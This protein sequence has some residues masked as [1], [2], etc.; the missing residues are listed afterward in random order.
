[1]GGNVT[2]SFR[3]SPPRRRPLLDY[4]ARPG[5]SWKR[6]PNCAW[7]DEASHDD[8]QVLRKLHNTHGPTWL[9]H[10]RLPKRPVDP[11]RFR[12]RISDR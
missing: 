4:A 10:Y 6:I 7:M 11:K 12:P 2:T 1:M 5:R 8:G 3:R 9:D